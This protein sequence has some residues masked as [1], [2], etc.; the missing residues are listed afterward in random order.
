MFLDGEGFN[1]L[2]HLL[3]LIPNWIESNWI[4]L[5]LS[6]LCYQLRIGETQSD[7]RGD[8]IEHFPPDVQ[9]I[10]QSTLQN[11][12]QIMVD[13]LPRQLGRRRLIAPQVQTGV[14]LLRRGVLFDI[15]H[16]RLLMLHVAHQIRQHNLLHVH[17]LIGGLEHVGVDGGD[18]RRHHRLGLADEDEAETLERF[19]LHGGVGVLEQGD[20]DVHQAVLHVA[21]GHV[22]EGVALNVEMLDDERDD[23]EGPLQPGHGLGIVAGMARRVHEDVPETLEEVTDNLVV[24]RD[25]VDHGGEAFHVV[26]EELWK[27]TIVWLNLSDST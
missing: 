3:L 18:P 26:L 23:A 2:K 13:D 15:R 4:E 17:V 22:A 8:E 7:H 9:L 24:G 5:N 6:L 25:V 11:T 10:V 14:L 12:L 20:E 16:Q 1:L 21:A 19:A 27:Y